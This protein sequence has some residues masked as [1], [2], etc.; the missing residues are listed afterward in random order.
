M[1]RHG[2]QGRKLRRD[3]DQRRALLKG[4]ATQL[5]EHG[6]V[7]TTLPKAKEVLPYAE[8]LITK[9]KKGGLHQRR[10][11]ISSLTTEATAHKL[12]DEIAPSL[13]GRQG[14]HLRLKRGQSRLGDNAQMATIS[15]V[16]DITKAA[17]KTAAKPVPAAKAAG[18]AKPVK[19]ARAAK[20]T[21]KAAALK[22][23]KQS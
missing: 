8:T 13:T 22:R 6:R 19:S 14:G 17:P 23:A 1:H 10:Q 11:L 16:D 2:Y 7:E 12:V 5:I 20:S 9:A 4:L 15:F 21:A 3:R 18:S